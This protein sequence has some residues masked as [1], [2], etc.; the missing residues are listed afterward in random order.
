M[1][2][3]E[4]TTRGAYWEDR[5]R[6]RPQMWS[7][8]P[9]G[10][11]IETV[12]ALSPGDALDLGCG[13]GADSMWLAEQGW[14]VLAADLAPT[15]LRRGAQEAKRRGLPAEQIR[16]LQADVTSWLPA[17]SF[18]LV[19]AAYLHSPGI[20]GSS[21][22]VPRFAQLVRPGGHLLVLSHATFPAGRQLPLH[23]QGLDVTPAEHLGRLALPGSQWHAEVSRRAPR[24]ASSGEIVEDNVLLLQRV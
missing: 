18:D 4:D 8:K 11:L 1:G 10:A 24:V 12:A 15:A 17:E 9:N 5:Y 21:G 19:L 20:G 13:E 7:G 3:T 16:W 2:M 6:T 14:R 23:L 22:T